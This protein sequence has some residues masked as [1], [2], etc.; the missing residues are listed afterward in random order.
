MVSTY[1]FN[2]LN[3]NMLL[4]D[5]CQ[6]SSMIKYNKSIEPLLINNESS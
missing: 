2:Q 6:T 4:D 3:S 1:T 5:T